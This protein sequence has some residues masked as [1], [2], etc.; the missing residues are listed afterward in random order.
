M[1]RH[2]AFAA[3]LAMITS[4][5]VACGGMGM[6]VDHDKLVKTASFDTNCPPE[7]I[8]IVSEDDQGMSGTGQYA[9]DVCGTQKKYKRAGTMYYDAEKGGPLG[10]H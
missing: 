6:G 1:L 9:L 4:T 8:K 5:L 3:G 2:T 7:K 10:A